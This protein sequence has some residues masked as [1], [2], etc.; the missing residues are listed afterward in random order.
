[1]ASV[2]LYLI[3]IDDTYQR[4]ETFSKAKASEIAANFIEAAYDPIKLNYRNGRFFC[5]AGQHRIYAHILMGKTS[6]EAELFSVISESLWLSPVPEAVS[7]CSPHSHLCR[8]LSAESRNQDAPHPQILREKPPRPGRHLS[9]GRESGWM[10]GAQKGRCLR[11]SVAL[12][13]P[14]SC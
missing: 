12:V 1:M 14:R 10:S 5:P 4:T 7:F 13:C 6:I 9:S 3:Y 8:L 2:P 11:S